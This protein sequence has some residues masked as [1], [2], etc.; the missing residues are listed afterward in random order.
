MRYATIILLAAVAAANAWPPWAP[1][2]EF[3]IYHNARRVA[4]GKQKI[5]HELHRTVLEYSPRKTADETSELV[6]ALVRKGGVFFLGG[7]L[8]APRDFATNLMK[9]HGSAVMLASAARLNVDLP[10]AAWHLD[11]SS[12]GYNSK[13]EHG[14][15]VPCNE[16]LPA[17][18][19][20]KKLGYEGCGILVPNPYFGTRAGRKQMGW[21][22]NWKKI[23]ASVME[24]STKTPVAARI[25]RAFWRGKCRHDER[26]RLED[27]TEARRRAHAVDGCVEDSHEL[28][29]RARL[30]GAALTVARRDLFDVKCEAD[31]F[32]PP[33][34][35]SKHFACV[36]D[37]LARA[38]LEDA[39]KKCLN[40]EKYVTDKHF[41]DMQEYAKYKY[42]LNLPGGTQGSYSRNLNHL[43]STGAAVLLWDASFVEWYYPALA[44]GATHVAI[45]RSTGIA[46]MERLEANP[47]E[48]SKLVAGAKAI[49]EL[50]TCPHC[51]AS[52]WKD[53][54]EAMRERFGYEAVLDD[55]KRLLP[56]VERA[57]ACD[58][59]PEC[60][61]SFGDDSSN[62]KISR[63]VDLCAWLRGKK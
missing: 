47:A 39:A 41:F 34:D 8:F 25:P 23:E 20:A 11:T 58:K 14:V 52:H 63:G 1:E 27:E 43:W 61:V 59:Y 54:F 57:G 55:P 56:V 16:S 5:R 32:D 12:T 29:K 9:E 36:R 22:A 19:I 24:M 44:S 40:H 2:T 51:L 46:T 49:A 38:E 42:V 31:Y 21:L 50:H 48:F 45:N 62:P 60:A 18:R 13:G 53:V 17:T 26:R 15:Y 10:N 30:L 6:E 28:G 37:P 33:K 7:R 3:G 4:T 35:P